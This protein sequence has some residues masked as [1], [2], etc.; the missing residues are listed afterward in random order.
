MSNFN[1]VLDQQTG[2]LYNHEGVR[3]TSNANLAGNNPNNNINNN[4][5]LVYMDLESVQPHFLYGNGSMNNSGRVP[6]ESSKISSNKSGSKRRKNSRTTLHKVDSYDQDFFTCPHVNYSVNHSGNKAQRRN[7]GHG[8]GS[9]TS[10]SNRNSKELSFEECGERDGY[11]GE[12]VGRRSGSFRNL[13]LLGNKVL[14]KKV[15]NTRCKANKKLRRKLITKV[16]KN[17]LDE[18]DEEWLL[19]F[20]N[21]PVEGEAYYITA[22]HEIVR[23]RRGKYDDDEEIME[24]APYNSDFSRFKQ[25][26]AYSGQPNYPNE[27]Q[28]NNNNNQNFFISP[29]HQAV[30]QQQNTMQTS[31]SMFSTSGEQQ[32]QIADLLRRNAKEGPSRRRR[33]HNDDDSSS[34]D[35][36]DSD[37]HYRK[38]RREVKG[39]ESVVTRPLKPPACNVEDII[40]PSTGADLREDLLESY[41]MDVKLEE[42]DFKLYE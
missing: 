4:N 32:Q 29:L 35:S 28:T 39:W 21:P 26:N 41:F 11:D 33:R 20:D 16:D 5:N 42:D 18:D 3:L 27:M 23:E 15:I 34:L 14:T 13:D 19:I 30:A 8:R 36:F 2:V 24:E 1:F 17:L 12:V 6:S 25:N 9:T 22:D 37:R 10:S 40:L 7:S 38:R 31:S